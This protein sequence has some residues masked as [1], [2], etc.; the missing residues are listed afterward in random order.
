[1]SVVRLFPLRDVVLFPHMV[2]PLHIFEPRYRQMTEDA[3]GADKGIAIV[4]LRP[5]ET[6]SPALP[7]IEDVAC[8]G[9][10]VRHQRLPDGRFNILLAGRRRVRLSR[11]VPSA[12]LY[13]IAEAETLADDYGTVDV[14]G[15]RS[16]FVTL[17]RNVL[18]ATQPEDA[19]FRWLWQSDLPLGVLADLA[20]PALNLP[21]DVRQS[22]LNEP[23]VGS[24][25]D[26]LF[27]ALNRLQAALRRGEDSARPFPPA[28]SNN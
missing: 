6:G 15:R 24:R 3:L 11:E 21:A 19:D 27:D 8:L 5:S 18:K 2:L 20:A 17:C 25:L 4:R 10:I 22:L 14:E 26:V 12:K 28:F 23:T 13:R 9:E 16:E 1:M 7:A